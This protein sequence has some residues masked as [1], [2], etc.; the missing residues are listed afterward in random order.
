MKFHGL[1]DLTEEQE[2]YHRSVKG[3]KAQEGQNRRSESRGLSDLHVN[4]HIG[5]SWVE[6]S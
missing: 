4:S 1:L 3:F 2:S 6:T 5:V